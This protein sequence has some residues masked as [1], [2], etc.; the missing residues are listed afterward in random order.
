LE[1]DR[2][3]STPWVLCPVSFLGLDMDSKVCGDC[4]IEKDISEFYKRKDSNCGVRSACKK[5]VSIQRRDYHIANRESDN[6]QK[7]KYK[8][9]HHEEIITK[10]REYYQTHRDEIKEKRLKYHRIH[11]KEQNARSREYAKRHP[12]RIKA[13][14]AFDYAIRNGKLIRPE[15]CS[16]PLCNCECK[17]EG[18]H[19]SYEEENWLDVIWSCCSCHGR[20]HST[21]QSETKDINWN[22]ITPI[23]EAI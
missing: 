20:I 23:K 1:S 5:C 7:R 2:Y 14:V 21:G 9:T 17:P 3:R 11:R 18:H 6:A 22:L 12:E 16:N 4:G 19:W 8:A 15:R 13:K 10:S